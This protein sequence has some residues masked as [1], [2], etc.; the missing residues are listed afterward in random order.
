MESIYVVPKAETTLDTV[1]NTRKE[2]INALNEALRNYSK[3]MEQFLIRGIQPA[4][5]LGL[6]NDEWK[7]TYDSAY[8]WEEKINKDIPENQFVVFFGFLN[9]AADPKTLSAKFYKDI[10]PIHMIQ[11]E[12]LYGFEQPYGYF[13]PKVWNENE[14][15]KVE[16]YGN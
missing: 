8:T 6:A 7:I 14:T 10:S 3:P 16:F 4:D 12:D 1:I 13:K 11:V 5:D 2:A 9:N 15:L